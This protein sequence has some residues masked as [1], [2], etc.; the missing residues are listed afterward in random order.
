MS[1]AESGPPQ[2]NAEIVVAGSDP[3]C[4][5]QLND[6]ETTVCGRDVLDHWEREDA[7]PDGVDECTRGF[8]TPN[9]PLGQAFAA[10]DP[11]EIG[12]GGGA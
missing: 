12:G 11:D 8:S 7:I 6:D 10:M 2:T 1:K 9:N 4:Y 5:H 3:D